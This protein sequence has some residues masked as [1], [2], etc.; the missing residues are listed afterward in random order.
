MKLPPSGGIFLGNKPQATQFVSTHYQNSTLNYSLQDRKAQRAAIRQARRSLP[1][2][3]QQRAARLVA[4]WAMTQTLFPLGQH[5]A[6]YMDADGEV[7]TQP[8]LNALINQGI[9]C[10][11]PVLVPETTTLEFRQYLPDRPLVTDF[12]GL[13]EP[14]ANAPTITPETLDTVFMPLVG[15][16]AA[17]NRLGMGKGYYDRTFSFLM[18]SDR[19]SP[20]LI[21]LAH[22]CQRVEKLEAADWDVPLS[23]IITPGCYYPVR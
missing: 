7:G 11:L 21:G 9:S 8:L 22:D 4:D 23:G 3:Q 16:D 17:G 13:L 18:S 20:R 12:F 19:E 15:F 14:A 2:E 5:I 6:I 1:L 10:Y